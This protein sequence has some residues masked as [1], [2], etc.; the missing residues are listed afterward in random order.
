MYFKVQ[1]DSDASR[2]AWLSRNSN[3]EGHKAATHSALS[4]SG[5]E[6]MHSSPRGDVHMFVKHGGSDLKAKLDKKLSAT[7]YSKGED[8]ASWNHPNGDSVHHS[9][10]NGSHVVQ[11]LS[12]PN[13]KPMTKPAPKPMTKPAL[14]PMTKPA[15][16][17]QARSAKTDTEHINS[18]AATLGI[19]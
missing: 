11:H 6:K 8:G 17:K 10:M 3:T 4:D 9:S 19:V 16:V 2:K 13:P 12:R 15:P 1:K 14:K 5:F 18:I 7:G